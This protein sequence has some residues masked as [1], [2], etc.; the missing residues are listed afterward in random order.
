MKSNV[1]CQSNRNP[2]FMIRGW[3][4]ERFDPD[5]VIQRIREAKDYGI[6]TISLSH[7]IVMNAEEIL[8]DWH[9][10]KHLRRFCD[11]AHKYDMKVYLWNHQINNPPE[12]LVIRD[13]KT[14]DLLLDF[15]NPKLWDWLF[16]RYQR[17]VDRVPNMDGIILSLTESEWQ[18]HRGPYD[19]YWF[20]KSRRVKSE[21]S[22]DQRMA[23]VIRTIYESLATRGKRLIVRDFFRTPTEMNYFVKAMENVPEEVWVLTKC[24]P[25]DW[26]YKYPPH[27]LLGKFKSRKQIMELDLYNEIGGN[28]NT[29]FLA[30]E[31]YKKQ[32]QM[33]RDLGLAG[34]IARLDDGFHTNKGTA[35]E[36]NVFV[37]N[38]LIH[39]PDADIEPMWMEFFLPYY[40]NEKAAKV[41]I[42]CLK[43][44]FDMV[45]ANAYTLGFWTGSCAPPLSYTDSHL[46]HHS[47]AI[48]SDDPKYAE[49]DRLLKEGGPEAIKRTVAEKKMAEALAAKSLKEL[50]A[51]K[52]HFDP[53]KYLEIVG[54]FEESL[55]QARINQIWVR[56]YYALRYYRNHP[57]STE[58]KEEAE[59]A[60]KALD[61]FIAAQPTVPQT[62]YQE[63]LTPEELKRFFLGGLERFR[64]EMQQAIEKIAAY[65]SKC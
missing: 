45:C 39:D 44:T 4:L 6:N 3:D 9:R 55:Q 16:V 1:V 17:V 64:E 60:L 11:E 36:F 62:P 43:R 2:C 27:P 46:E 57:E 48:W 40:G 42:K 23:K 61:D 5:Y 7:E 65:A 22:P 38:R 32:I 63:T 18:I 31:Y 35:K 14:G 49:I 34:V 56:A 29:I 37:Y 28:L 58:A 33:A 26:Q 12:E 53:E 52:E 30:P 41:A 19:P 24:V 13:P 25:N 47:T 20:R 21:M 8:Y 50:E 54:Y 15:D 51:A 59:V 10:Y